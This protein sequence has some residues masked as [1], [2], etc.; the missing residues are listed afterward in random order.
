M[1]PP[2]KS[3]VV[4]K[5][6]L[7]VF[8][9]QTKLLPLLKEHS[10]STLVFSNS[11]TLLTSKMYSNSVSS[12]GLSLWASLSSSLPYWGL[13]PFPIYERKFHTDFERS[14]EYDLCAHSNLRCQWLLLPVYFSH[15]FCSLLV[16]FCLYT[17]YH[18]LL[19]KYMKTVTFLFQS[20]LFVMCVCK[21][22]IAFLMSYRLYTTRYRHL[23]VSDKQSVMCLTRHAGTSQLL[24]YCHQSFSL[25]SAHGSNNHRCWVFCSLTQR[26][27]G[28]LDNE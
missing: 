21:I 25:S 10:S 24:G 11:P 22:K 28:T 8:Q 23:S 16:M 6:Y 20:A 18:V 1:C 19:L 2:K 4:A 3:I 9:F 27:E 5:V 7:C 26:K 13:R 14:L 15:S 17:S 12:T